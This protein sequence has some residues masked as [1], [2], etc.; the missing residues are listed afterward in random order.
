MCVYRPSWLETM[1][2]PEYCGGFNEKQVIQD[3][4]SMW[5]SLHTTGS[6]DPSSGCIWN[7][8]RSHVSVIE[9]Y[10]ACQNSIYIYIYI[11]D[12]VFS[13]YVHK[14]RAILIADWTM[15]TSIRLQQLAAITETDC[16]GDTGN[17]I[18]QPS[19]AASPNTWP[20]MNKVTGLK[21]ALRA[22]RQSRLLLFFHL[23]STVYCTVPPELVRV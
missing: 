22:A 15:V 7:T 14:Q 19:A 17:S 20:Q 5:V 2:T 8:A 9:S 18:T 11:S 1:K 21:W 13:L 16:W 4:K 3:H 12:V 23:G 6:G 10:S